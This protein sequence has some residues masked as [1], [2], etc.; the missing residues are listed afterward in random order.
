MRSKTAER[1]RQ[2]ASR[3]PPAARFFMHLLGPWSQGP[4]THVPPPPHN[5]DYDYTA[6]HFWAISEAF[7]TFSAARIHFNQQPKV[8]QRCTA[9]RSRIGNCKMTSLLGIGTWR[10]PIGFWAGNLWPFDATTETGAAG[11]GCCSHGGCAF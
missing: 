5:H 1:A 3:S 11:C 6:R 9:P 8:V 7:G 2:H 4:H 10:I